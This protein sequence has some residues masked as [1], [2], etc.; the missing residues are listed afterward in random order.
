MPT[1]VYMTSHFGGTRYLENYAEFSEE[2][3]QAFDLDTLLQPYEDAMRRAVPFPIE[4][5]RRIVNE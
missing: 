3:L 1:R 2:Q 5:K 4:I